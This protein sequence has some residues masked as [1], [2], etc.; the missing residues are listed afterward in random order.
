VSL[1]AAGVDLV[2]PGLLR[3]DWC[4]EI[5]GEAGPSVDLVAAVPLRRDWCLEIAEEA[6]ASV[7]LVAAVLLRRDWCTTI[8]AETRRSAGPAGFLISLSWVRDPARP[9]QR[10]YGR[11]GRIRAP[12]PHPARRR[13]TGRPT[14]TDPTGRRTAGTVASGW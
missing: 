4:T 7:D 12:S 5:V 2:A 1:T 13:P 10:P 6:G 11:K 9:A 8:G 3:R 14:R